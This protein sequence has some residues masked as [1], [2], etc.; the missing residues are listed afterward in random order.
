M[1]RRGDPRELPPDHIGQRLGRSQRSVTAEPDGPVVTASVRK[2]SGELDVLDQK[3]A[4][5]LSEM[6]PV[7][8]CRT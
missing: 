6:R 2:N 8:D 5:A 1:Q 7:T 4:E 3:H